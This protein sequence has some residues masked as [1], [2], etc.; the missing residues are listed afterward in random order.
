MKMA[1]IQT[2]TIMLKE[3]LIEKSQKGQYQLT[4]K[5]TEFYKTNIEKIIKS[6]KRDLRNL[7]FVV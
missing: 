4:L 3:G 7:V 2:L 1:L 6:T 5:G